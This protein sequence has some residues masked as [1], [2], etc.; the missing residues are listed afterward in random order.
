MV[1]LAQTPDLLEGVNQKTM[2]HVY[3]YGAS[4][5]CINSWVLLVGKGF[6]CAKLEVSQHS[7]QKGT[8]FTYMMLT[9]S[10]T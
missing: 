8:L 6:N 3:V 10:V 2:V 9:A 1:K 5:C 7:D 4:E